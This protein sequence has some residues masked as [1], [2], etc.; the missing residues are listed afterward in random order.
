MLLGP[1]VILAQVF[2]LSLLFTIYD[3]WASKLKKWKKIFKDSNEYLSTSYNGFQQH[4]RCELNTLEMAYDLVQAI[5]HHND[6][7]AF[8]SGH[9]VTSVKTLATRVLHP[10]NSVPDLYLHCS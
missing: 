8:P 10:I 9:R 1:A 4:L 6:S 3:V 2:G 7:V 5:L